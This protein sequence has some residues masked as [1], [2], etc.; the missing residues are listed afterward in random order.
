MNVTERY[1][2]D[3][4]NLEQLSLTALYELA[5]PSLPEGLRNIV[6]E[7]VVA[8]GEVVS[9]DEI[10][11][12]RDENAELSDTVV[13]LQAQAALNQIPSVVTIQPNHEA[14]EKQYQAFVV[15]WQALPWDLR[16]RFWREFKA[17]LAAQFSAYAVPQDM[18]GNSYG[19]NGGG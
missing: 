14:L 4:S 8:G 15:H 10:R 11:R 3:R 19:R 6:E 17:P 16:D 1:Y 5:S 18:T 12:L 9:A 7:R 2:D 13:E